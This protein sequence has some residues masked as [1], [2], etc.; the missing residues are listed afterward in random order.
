M[1]LHDLADLFGHKV[2]DITRYRTEYGEQILAGATVSP[3]L[4][5][6]EWTQIKRFIDRSRLQLY[7]DYTVHVELGNDL[8]LSRRLQVSS[9]G[10]FY[11]RESAQR[12]TYGCP[13]ETSTD[14]RA[15]SRPPPGVFRLKEWLETPAWAFGARKPNVEPLQPEERVVAQRRS[16]VVPPGSESPLF[17]GSS[18]ALLAPLRDLEG[19]SRST[20]FSEVLA[21][22]PA[23]GV[24]CVSTA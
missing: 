5:I 19:P 6:S 2:G 7:F 15:F 22:S 13:E 14:F 9:R 17:L 23:L 24:R 1:V 20:H 10:G 18:M 12:W 21:G 16:P 3:K 4:G 11:F 8:S